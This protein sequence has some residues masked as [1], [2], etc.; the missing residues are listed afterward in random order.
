MSFRNKNNVVNQIKAAGIV[1]LFCEANAGKANAIIREIALAGFTVIEFTNRNEQAKEVFQECLCYIKKEFPE[2]I[3]GAGSVIDYETAEFYIGEGADFIVSPCID[4][5]VAELCLKKGV[6]Y[7]PGC[8]TPSEIRTAVKLGC[9]LIKIFPASLLGGPEFI[10][11]VLAP[12]KGLS[13]M[14]AGGVNPDK[15]SMSAWFD[16]G[17][18]CLAMG[19]SLIKKEFIAKENYSDLGKFLKQVKEDLNNLRT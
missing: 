14:P 11:A 4:S 8:S 13:L 15:E 9:E 10:K 7:S 12:M 6:P 3:L 2:V 5:D 17:A 16:A 18:S 19:S 1:P